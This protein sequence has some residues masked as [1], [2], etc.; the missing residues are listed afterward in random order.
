VN[1]VEIVEL[2]A[3]NPDT[4]N[5]RK[6]NARNVGMIV[7]A[8]HEVGTGRSGVIDENNNVLAGNATMAAL[9]KAGIRRVKVVNASGSE[10]VVV[11]RTGLSGKQKKRLALYDNRGSELSTWDKE[12]MAELDAESLLDG[13]FSDTEKGK[14]DNDDNENS[15]VLEQA[16][17]LKPQREYIIVMCD[18]ESPDQYDALVDKLN[19]K[20]VRRG[21]Y[22]HGSPFDITRRQRV[23]LASDLIQRLK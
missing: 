20:M 4:K 13:M 8:L 15:V 22:K 3:L 14:F 23:V 2:S 16:V 11:R 1:D 18:P 7:D 5:A 12:M 17:Q 21:G 6:H 9:G 19:L 10:W